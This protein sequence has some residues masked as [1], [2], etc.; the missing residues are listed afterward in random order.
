[1]CA[2]GL[3]PRDFLFTEQKYALYMKLAGLVEVRP[4]VGAIPTPKKTLVLG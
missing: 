3:D 1:M 2:Q 4:L